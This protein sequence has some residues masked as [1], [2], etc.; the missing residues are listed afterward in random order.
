MTTFGGGENERRLPLVG[1]EP[2]GGERDLERDND[3]HRVSV[4]LN[5]D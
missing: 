3:L 1:D 4:G 2:R 5:T